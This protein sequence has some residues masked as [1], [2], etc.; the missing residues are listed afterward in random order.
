MFA[1]HHLNNV[2]TNISIPILILSHYPLPLPPSLSLPYTHFPRDE[3]GLRHVEGML[4]R[5]F[6]LDNVRKNG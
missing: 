6:R 1:L 5:M 4:D 2:D 3:D